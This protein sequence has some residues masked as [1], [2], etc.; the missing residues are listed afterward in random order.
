MYQNK[1]S[2]MWEVLEKL[3]E[4]TENFRIGGGFMTFKLK[5][6]TPHGILRKRSEYA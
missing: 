6:V 5:I 2:I 4:K 1:L 3:F